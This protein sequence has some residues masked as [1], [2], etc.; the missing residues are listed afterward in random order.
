MSRIT[1]CLGLLFTLGVSSRA[2]SQDT[3]S[4][5]ATCKNMDSCFNEWTCRLPPGVPRIAG[6]A[7]LTSGRLITDD[8]RGSYTDARD[9]SDVYVR[10][11]VNLYV[12]APEVKPDAA[13]RRMRIDMTQPADSAAESLGI[14]EDAYADFHA[15]GPSLARNGVEPTVQYLRVGSS[16]KS[17]FVHVDFTY[18]GRYYLLLL[19]REALGE[20][21]NKP[22][23]ALFTTGTST[24]TISRPQHN[25][26][27]I[28]APE[29]SIGRLFD[30]TNKIAGAVNK[31]LYYTSFKLVF[32]GQ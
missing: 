1:A 25:V 7:T 17:A 2:A 3:S 15:W 32:E 13:R 26:Y 22:A 6:T 29:G 24:A 19:G 18:Q 27:V 21:C 14:I 8:G 23:T 5:Q 28:E 30:I 20:G 12:T 10:A 31:G 11:A 16:H 9:S 4:S